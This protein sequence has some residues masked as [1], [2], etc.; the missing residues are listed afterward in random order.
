MGIIICSFSN[1][2]SPVAEYSVPTGRSMKAVSGICFG[3]EPWSHIV[4]CIGEIIW[5]KLMEASFLR[6][7]VWGDDD[8]HSKSGFFT[9]SGVPD[10]GENRRCSKYM[11][12]DPLRGAHRTFYAERAVTKRFLISRW[13]NL[14]FL[15]TPFIIN[16][17]FLIIFGELRIEKWTYNYIFIYL[18]VFI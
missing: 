4:Q 2:L 16:I 3:S 12:P 1:Y 6:G 7:R 10:G 5:M 9:V 14:K 11:M 17:I 8:L 13:N 15:F 18:T